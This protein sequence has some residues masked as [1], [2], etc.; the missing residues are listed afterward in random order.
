MQEELVNRFEALLLE[1]HGQDDAIIE[2]CKQGVLKDFYAKSKQARE[3][4]EKIECAQFSELCKLIT[5]EHQRHQIETVRT[6]Q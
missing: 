4:L 1:P 6:F 2:F 3:P 5:D